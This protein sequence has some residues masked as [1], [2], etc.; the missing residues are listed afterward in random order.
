VFLFFS[1]LV[2]LAAAGCTARYSD[3]AASGEDTCVS[4]HGETARFVS[5]SVHGT[6]G[7]GCSHCHSEAAAHLKDRRVSPGVDYSGATCAVCHGTEYHEWTSSPHAVIPLNLL[8]NDTRIMECL[9]CHQAGG[10]AAVLASGGNFK[11]AKAPP[12]TRE[13]EPVT[14]VACHTPHGGTDYKLLR[15]PKE[16][17]CAACHGG[18]WQNLVLN[19]TG[20]HQYPGRDYTVFSAHPH[21]SVGHC[22]TCHMARTPGA[23]GVGG[24]TF[25]MRAK[26]GGQQNTGACAACHGETEDYNISG[27]QHEVDALLIQLRTVLEERNN[28]SL[29]G[30]QPGACNQCHRG[31]TLP[32]DDDPELIL[33]EAYENYKLVDRDK[34]RGVHNPG[35]A[36]QLLRDSLE[37]VKKE[38]SR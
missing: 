21:N 24:H 9:K 31:G 7:L 33:E 17:L 19:G 22:A 2:L 14:C 12:P 27:R 11:N 28:G 10:F 26:D 13:P 23:D 25:S 37:S 5:A 30:F 20:G 1:V 32:F 4:C 3:S 15:L 35:Y 36:L 34:S 16:E 6:E 18:K 8:P 29:P 38:Y